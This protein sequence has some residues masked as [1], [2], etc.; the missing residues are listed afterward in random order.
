MMQQ[1]I[2]FKG[3][4]KTDITLII[5]SELSTDLNSEYAK[6]EQITTTACDKHFPEKCVKFNKHKHNS[7]D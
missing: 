7:S 3:V 2:T 1:W 5:G 6:F 4:S